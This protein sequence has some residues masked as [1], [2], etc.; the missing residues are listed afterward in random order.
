MPRK[1]KELGSFQDT[2]EYVNRLGFVNPKDPIMYKH[3]D[4]CAI[5]SAIEKAAD[6]AQA[7]TTYPISIR[8]HTFVSDHGY[9]FPWLGYFEVKRGSHKEQLRMSSVNGH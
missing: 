2:L 7:G 4:L 6:K 5:A 3:A 1:M 9:R 8:F